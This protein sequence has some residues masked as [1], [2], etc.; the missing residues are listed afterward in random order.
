MQ[1]ERKKR[2]KNVI[3]CE[4]TLEVSPHQN[5]VAFYNNIKIYYAQTTAGI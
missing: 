3:L 2:H 5:F 4:F 1:R